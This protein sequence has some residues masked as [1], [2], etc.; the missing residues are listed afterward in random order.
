MISAKDILRGIT[1]IGQV[2]EM[3]LFSQV[4]GN[5]WMGGCP[6]IQAPVEFDFII[7]LY[8]WGRYEI[9][10]HQVQVTAR[11]Y[12][13]AEIPDEKLLARLTH[14]IRQFCVQGKVLV[15][16]QMGLNRS[17]LVVALTLIESGMKPADAIGLLRERRSMAVL[18]NSTFERW[19]LSLEF[20][21]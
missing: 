1:H 5:L 3:P 20:L 6:V 13:A 21:E 9:H 7:N 11:L 12:D 8:P 19:L 18:C 10:A 17:P 15:H 16:C 2:V 4:T 14:L